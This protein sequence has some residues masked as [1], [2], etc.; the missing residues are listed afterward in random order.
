M[1]VS[2]RI[3]TQFIWVSNRSA[4]LDG[5][6]RKRGARRLRTL[7]HRRL[8]SPTRGRGHFASARRH[9][10]RNDRRARVGEGHGNAR[11]CREC[12][13]SADAC[14]RG[15]NAGACCA[16]GHRRAHVARLTARPG[17]SLARGLT[18]EH[19]LPWPRGVRS[20]LFA[21]QRHERIDAC[22]TAGRDVARHQRYRSEYN[23]GRR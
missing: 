8:R 9:R 15:G 23:G 21:P 18:I 11:L 5:D 13:R 3:L 20:W 10:G 4:A 1:L 19:V 17:K 2:N 7:T 22:G 6:Q 14:W 16:D 12:I